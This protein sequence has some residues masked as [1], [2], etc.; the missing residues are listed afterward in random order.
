MDNLCVCQVCLEQV[1]FRPEAVVVLAHLACEASPLFLLLH[2]VG[3]PPPACRS[4]GKE[5]RFRHAWL[6]VPDRGSHSGRTTMMID[7]A[8]YQ[9]GRRTGEGPARLAPRDAS[10]RTGA[11]ALRVCL[12]AATAAI[13]TLSLHDAL[14]I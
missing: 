13:Y 2:P 9:D 7:C 1:R 8:N 11:G 12:D 10:R 3:R 6:C 14:P 5:Q 4:H